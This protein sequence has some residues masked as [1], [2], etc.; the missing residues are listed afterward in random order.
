MA[1]DGGAEGGLEGGEGGGA[2]LACAALDEIREVL[3]L[4]LTRTRARTRT[5]TLS[6]SLSLSLTLTLTLTLTL[7]KAK[8]G[9]TAL[10][11]LMRSEVLRLRRRPSAQE[12]I[13]LGQH[14]GD[15]ASPVAG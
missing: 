5:R 3:T 1:A 14:A 2:R 8:E 13:A 6:L 7:R 12:A 15:E 4:A 11:K 9:D 10:K